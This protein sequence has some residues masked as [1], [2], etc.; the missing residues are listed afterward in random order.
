LTPDI[1]WGMADHIATQKSTLT[2]A[3]SSRKRRT[4]QPYVRGF[5]RRVNVYSKLDTYTIMDKQKQAEECVLYVRVSTIRQ[6]EDGV[7]IDAQIAKGKANAE[8]NDFLLPKE[9][10]FIDDGVS[11]K[12]PLWS[13]PA[14]KQM[15]AFIL[16]HK[17]KQIY[18]YRMD[19]LFRSTIDCLATVEELDEFGIG[20]QFCESGGQPLDLSSA[21]GRMLITILAAFGEMERNLISE[22]VCMAMQ[23]LKET[24]RRYTYDKYGWDVDE[25]NNF[26]ENE[27]EQYWIE[28]IKVRYHEDG[29]T[30]SE[31][32]R[33]LNACG[34]PTK[35]GKKWSHKQVSRI[36]NYE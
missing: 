3:Y 33:E 4:Q 22:R 12:I 27:K 2:S 25:D 19:R 9:N 23:Y 11:A 15:K 10:I 29:I 28:Y 8:F 20:I 24:G 6:A 36:L 7:S 18:A 17:I 13:R 35:R 1:G 14:A 16:K 30:K 31:I 34:V 21:V 26:I 5:G 32:A